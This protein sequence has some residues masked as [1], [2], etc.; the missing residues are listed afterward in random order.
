[1]RKVAVIGTTAWGT[2]LAVMLAARD[3]EVMIWARTEDEAERLNRDRENAAHLPAVS[4][5]ERL[6]A[7][8][9]AAEALEGADLAI[10]AVPSQTMRNNLSAIRDHLREPVSILSLSKGIE[11]E[12]TRRMSEVI[13]EELAPDFSD[14]IAVLS[15]PNFAR[16]VV[17]GLP[18]ATVIAAANIEFAERIQK[19]IS[20]PNFRAYVNDDIVGVELAGALKN[21]IALAA[22]MSDGLGYGDNSRAA[23][24]TR[25][26]AEITRLGVAAGA[27]PL[28]FAGLAGIGDLVATCTSQLSRNRFVGQELARGRPLQEITSSMSGIAE[29]VDTAAAA[30]RLA[31]RLG[32]EMPVTE[33]VYRVLFEGL[34]VKEGVPALMER[35]LKHEVSADIP[36]AKSLS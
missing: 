24:I 29:G 35:E 30:R 28:T 16:E 23:L 1:M 8:S 20:S 21:I 11:I 31:H 4:F 5:P 6:R 3:M 12:T 18:T 9:S 32:V 22:G 10:L 34:A 33:Q 2:T 26:L 13:A 27:R 36:I 25:G 19:T 15:G 14:R 17:Q 7:T